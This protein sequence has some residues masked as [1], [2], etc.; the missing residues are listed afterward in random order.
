M[1]ERYKDPEWQN[2]MRVKVD[3]NNMFKEYIGAE[4]GIKS[5]HV[6]SLEEKVVTAHQSIE[7]QYEEGKLGFMELPEQQEEVID[8][9]EQF[10]NNNR[11]KF[12]NFVILGIGG[13]ALGSIA[14]QTALKSPYHN[15]KEEDGLNIYV[16]DNVDPERFKSLLDT[17]DLEKTVFNVISKSGSTAETMSLFLIARRTVEE[18]VG[19]DNISEHFIAT[20]SKDSGYLR[21]IAQREGFKMFYIP[22]NVGGRFSVLTP[23]GLVYAAFAGIDIR[24]LLAGAAYMKRICS[25]PDVWENPAYLSGLLQYLAYQQGKVMSVMMPYAHSLKDVAD[26]YRQ[27]WAESLGKEKDR[28]GETVNVGPTPIK[29]L[30]ATDQHSQAQLYMEGPYDKVVNFIEVKE[31]H[32]DIEIPDLYEDIKGVS[33]LRGKSLAELLKTEKKATEL[34][35]TRR[36]R[37]NNTVIVPKVNEFTM[38]QMFYLFELETAFVGELFNINAYNQPGVELG[39]HYTYGVFGR[40][41]YEDKKEE[42]YD[43]PKKKDKYIV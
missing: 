26:W 4:H 11:D 23:V 37:L 2:K 30:G 18:A 43:R 21:V 40:E 42:Y 32:Q 5:E 35:L 39:K 13:S 22:D 34:A 31:F 16:P 36:Q 15:L 25:T 28:E 33:Y 9:I 24:E 14:L 7:K 12:D 27:L 20:T 3:V 38:G 1:V 17:L 19:Q 6:D 41:G 8:E 10:A 29:A